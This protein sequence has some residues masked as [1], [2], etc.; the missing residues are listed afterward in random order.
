MSEERFDPDKLSRIAESMVDSSLGVVS[1]DNLLIVYN[2]GG[3]QL[4]E[5]IKT[6]ATDRK[7]DV[8]LQCDDPLED[9][10]FLLRLGEHPAADAFHE[11]VSVRESNANWASKFAM[12][13]CIETPN[14]MESVAGEI[15]SEFRRVLNVVNTI[16]N[17]KDW[18]LTA[19]P[20]EAEAELDG[21]PYESYVDLYFRACNRDWKEVEKAQD[22]LIQEV[23]NPAKQLE[24]FADRTFLTMSIEG[25][26]F[27]N[28]TIQRNIPGSEV[29]TGPKRGT[30]EGRLTL[31]Y[32][33]MFGG[34]K[35]PNLTFRFID[36]RVAQFE[37]DGED[38][39]SRVEH[40]LDT[41]EGAREVGEVAL[42]TNSVLNRPMLNTLYV[43][44]VGGS[45]HIA[46]GRAYTYTE[47]A[48]R[49]VHVDNGVKSANHIDLTRL[50]LPQF[51]GGKVIVD[52]KVIQQ[53]GRF[54]DRRL[55]ILNPR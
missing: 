1:G 24:F 11:L 38:N 54:V 12:I 15:L 32:P 7:V 55:A 53:D 29:F 9:A 19:I 51:G 34:R 8:R 40:V 26:T 14:S 25:Q 52:G 36:G 30:V 27:A 41:D 22:I 5:F 21:I 10:Q 33:L 16:R 2:P 45:F 50:M 42:G 35:L 6:L 46:L 28:S 43:E 13:R 31:Q 17:Q 39:M 23:L 4:A 18:V 3:A 49:P 48:G 47:Y 37:T 20:T 44:K